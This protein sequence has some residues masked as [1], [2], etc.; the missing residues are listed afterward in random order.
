[1]LDRANLLALMKNVAKA[2]PSSTYS[3]NG[4]T[5]QY[6][7]MNETL[8]SELNALADTD[9]L[10][11]AN[12][13]MIFSLIAET[14]DEVVPNRLINA[15]GQFAEIKQFAQGD[16][17]VFVRRTGTQRAKQFVTHAG[18][19]G[20]YEVFKLGQESFEVGTSA[21]GAAAQIGLEEFLDG[22]VDFAE[23]TQI[24]MDGMDE[25]IYREIAAALQSA[26]TQLPAVNSFV[27]QDFQEAGFDFLV[28]TAAAYGTPV[29]YCT[30]EFAVKMV[31]SDGW[32]SDNM[33]DQRWN[34][35][36]LANYK[37]YQVV[38]LPQTLE[39]E[40]N[41][42]KMIDPSYAWIIPAGTNNKPVKVAFEG[43]THL[44]ERDDN[45]DWSRDIQVFRKVGVG[46]MM[47]SNIFCYRDTSLELANTKP[48]EN[49]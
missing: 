27:S 40:T 6:N 10:Y 47:T 37:G 49:Q 25:L 1:M 44:R 14:L 9:E 12:K 24:I 20:V 11:Q 39:D 7:A 31:P 38:I 22:R 35:G 46:V 15:Y 26:I 3:V 34:T 16:R 29:I 36:Y 32:I 41:S 8:R 45:D 28:N 19:A 17:P 33:R 4:Q 2:N 43:T 13:G 5:L 48:T 18:L 42:M 23:L 30:R 21:M